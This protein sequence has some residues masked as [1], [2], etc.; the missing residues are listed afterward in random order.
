MNRLLLAVVLICHTGLATAPTV[1]AH[2]T[3]RHFGSSPNERPV[4]KP[5]PVF[6]EMVIELSLSR[7]I[8]HIETAPEKL[9]S[10]LTKLV[11]YAKELAASQPSSPEFDAFSKFTLEQ[12]ELIRDASRRGRK[13][14]AIDGIGTLQ[15]EFERLRPKIQKKRQSEK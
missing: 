13:T 8:D 11:R 4:F 15:G 14:P 5:S 12:V 10:D 3:E 2:G 9:A 6:I 1:Y 7:A